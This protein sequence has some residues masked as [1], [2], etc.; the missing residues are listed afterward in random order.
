M[1][2]VFII[3]LSGCTW[4][5]TDTDDCP[6]GT[7]VKIKY[8]NNLLD[9]DAAANQVRD[10]SIFMFDSEGNYVRR[11]E[12]DYNQLQRDNYVVEV[13]GLPYGN[14][15]FVVWAGLVDSHFM[16]N[17]ASRVDDFRLSLVNPGD[18]QANEYGDLFF[19]RIDSVEVAG[20]YAV[21]E[22]DMTKDTNIVSCHVVA[23]A[24]EDIQAERYGVRLV[25]SNGVINARNELVSP[26]KVE[27]VPFLFQYG[28]MADQDSGILESVGYDI[29]TLR[30]VENDESRLMLTD[31]QSGTVVVDIPL[32]KLLCQIA[33]FYTTSGKKLTP[34]EYLDRQD[35]HT[36]IFYLSQSGSQVV[37]CRINNWIV[38]LN[39]YIVL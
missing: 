39:D 26:A 32:T 30:L 24:S 38:R 11:V 10:V 6:T 21:H 9:V 29:K 23:S 28:T 19:G 13:D 31:N 35:F 15:D 27:Y 22:I 1:L 5:K 25:T 7:W 36:V 8:A 2:A 4:V 16:T 18:V 33:S 37:Q 20:K 14:Y 17:S 3:L 12:V 34:Q